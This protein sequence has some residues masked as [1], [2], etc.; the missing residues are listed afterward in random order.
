MARKHLKQC[1]ETLTN[2]EMQIK[3]ILRFHLIPV[4]MAKMKAHSVE[5]V[6]QEHFPTAG[7][8]ANLFSPFGKQYNGFSEIW[9]SSC[10]KTQL[11][12]S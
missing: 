10:H 5:D 1:S 9:E 7:G 12:H 3:T 6:E 4:R 8:S 11:Y 2:R